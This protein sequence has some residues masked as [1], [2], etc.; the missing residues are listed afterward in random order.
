MKQIGEECA[1]VEDAGTSNAI[2]MLRLL[3]YRT[4]DVKRD[5]YVCFQDHIKV[6][7]TVR[8]EVMLEMLQNLYIDRKDIQC[9]WKLYWEPT[10]AILINR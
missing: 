3:N 10:A 2:F 5:M 1:F 8:Q 6:F 9:I 4:V 7:D